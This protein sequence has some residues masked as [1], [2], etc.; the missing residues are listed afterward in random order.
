MCSKALKAL[1]QRIVRD[2][3]LIPAE[4]PV[5]LPRVRRCRP[6]AAAKRTTFAPLPA[7]TGATSADTATQ[8]DTE[9]KARTGTTRFFLPLLCTQTVLLRLAEHSAAPSQKKRKCKHVFEDVP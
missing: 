3:E 5:R 8:H 4:E 6:S 2:L 9:D 1:A 7:S